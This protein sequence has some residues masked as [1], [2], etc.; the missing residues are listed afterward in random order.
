MVQDNQNM[1][2]ILKKIEDSAAD[3]TVPK[4]LEPEQVKE[5]LERQKQQKEHMKK[6]HMV[7]VAAAVALVAVLGGS[8]VYGAIMQKSGGESGTGS[9]TV[10]ETKEVENGQSERM[11]AAAPEP[12]KQKVGSYHLAKDYNEVY[13]SVTY[14]EDERFSD[15]VEGAING[16]VLS[17]NE[18]YESDYSTMEDVAM[19]AEESAGT[20]QG[21]SDHSGTNLQVEG[22]DES[23]Y[24][25]NDGN[26]LYLQ[27]NHKISIVDIRDEK[28]K[29]V[30]SLEPDMGA[31][32]NIMDMYVDGDYVYLILQK[33][34]TQLSK[35]ELSETDS[36]E[37]EISAHED[38]V[39]MD[40]KSY[41]E[42]Q[43][44]D[45]EDR[46]QAKKTG[47]VTLDGYYQTSRKNGDYI[48]LFS[49]KYIGG[50]SKKDKDTLIPEING[51]K[52]E[53]NC[54]YIQDNASSELMAVSV[55]VKNPNEVVDRMVLLNADMQ[56]YMGTDSFV[57]Y[58]ENYSYT[59]MPQESSTDL[60]KFSYKDGYMNAVAAASV[61]G[62]IMDPFA[63][64][65]EDGILRVLTTEWSANSKNQLFLLDENLK[66]LGALRDLAA[67][68]EIYAAR[69][70][71]DI[72]YFITYHN[73]DPLFAVDISDPKN[74]KMLGQL[75]VTGYSDYL[76]PYGDNL[77]LGIGY[78]TDPDTSETLGVKLTMFD[79]TNPKKLKVLD[80][81][82]VK[83]DYC[84]A[85]ENYKCA[86]VDPKKNLIG[87]QATKWGEKQIS[88][89]YVYSWDGEHFTSQ[90]TKKMREEESYAYMEIRG[91]YA[92]SRFYLVN[93]ENS[94]Y[95]IRS[96]DMDQKYEE[97][98]DL[99]IKCTPYQG[100]NDTVFVPNNMFID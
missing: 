67:G 59:D 19:S 94:G 100:Y 74:P 6:S 88:R 81:V 11:E 68:E 37:Y 41:L 32:D 21:S 63:I 84:A 71:G 33:R 16:G 65:E 44:Y 1:E 29:N 98:D 72:A 23:D 64:S 69:Y 43:T 28:M 24:I 42:L 76:H 55:N 45:I 35:G 70:V 95:R 15:G 40:S 31:S 22:V 3:V 47:S 17:K 10:N 7:E 46:A 58:G 18:K 99:R 14:M 62:T 30:A 2:E 93:P 34:D 8:G 4:E 60:T 48:Y 9:G 82:T 96:Y 78:E 66:L 53:S 89:Y 52:A 75:K 13:G 51:K 80:S 54:I 27:T 20:N 56:L 49:E 5:K 25:K 85:A 36:E 91:E 77:L 61:S 86:L 90:F 57:L 26:Y 38:V 12:K 92:G 97:L 50:I 39:Y 79:T 83:G 73:T 87:F